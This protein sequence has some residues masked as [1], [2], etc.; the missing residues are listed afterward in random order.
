MYISVSSGD[1]ATPET[2]NILN[3]V[4]QLEKDEE[5]ARQLQVSLCSSSSTGEV[6]GDTMYLENTNFETII[7]RNVKFHTSG[8]L[9]TTRKC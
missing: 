9:Y 4:S 1:D 2:R 5:V 6:I 3:V 7:P 8:A